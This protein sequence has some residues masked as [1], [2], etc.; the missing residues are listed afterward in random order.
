[1]VGV[2][3]GGVDGADFTRT[4][5]EAVICEGTSTMLKCPEGQNVAVTSA[6]WGRGDARTCSRDEERSRLARTPFSNVTDT[7]RRLCDNRSRCDV[8]ADVTTF[9]DLR[10]G[11]AYPS[12]YLLANYSC[13]S[14]FIYSLSSCFL[15]F[16]IELTVQTNGTQVGHS[17]DM[18]TLKTIHYS[19]GILADL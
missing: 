2:E 13:R 15:M 4:D 19:R 18:P 10:A 3:G 16:M 8:T 12:L 14:I 5:H 17:S 1:M 9:G 7:L 6:M 11:G